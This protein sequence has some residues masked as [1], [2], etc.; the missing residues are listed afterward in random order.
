MFSK[1][2]IKAK[3]IVMLFI[4]I[5]G[6][7]GY[8]MYFIINTYNIKQEAQ[9]SKNAVEKII[10][11]GSVIHESQK[12][13][14]TT[15]GFLSGGDKNSMLSQRA[16]NDIALKKLNDQK[17]I[18]KINNIRSSVDSKSSSNLKLVA[19]YTNFIR[20]IIK[21][22]R[23][24][25]D[26]I[27]PSLSIYFN[28]AVLIGDLKESYGIFR[29]TLNSVFTKD[30]MSKD[31]FSRVVKY[32]SETSK[33]N[34]DFLE[35]SGDKF[36]SFYEQNVLSKGSYSK[37]QDFIKMALNSE[38][39]SSL[40]ADAKVWFNSVTDVIN[41]I[42]EVELWI[43]NLMENDAKSIEDS[44]NTLMGIGVF[45]AALGTLLPLILSVIIGGSLIKNINL[46]QDGLA[47]FFE[48]L[49]YEKDDAKII[50]INSNDEL[51]AMSLMIN[52]NIERTQKAI[53]QDANAINTALTSTKEI[54]NGNLSTR[55]DQ[56]AS[57]PKLCEL[58]EV[59]NKMLSMF[60]QKIGSNLTEILDIFDSYKKLD[61]RAKVPNASGTIESTLNILGDEIRKTLISSNSFAQELETK[62]NELNTCMQD[63][64]NSAKVQN[65]S[66]QNS[67]EAVK[68][69]DLSINEISN[70]SDEV[71]S[72]SE[73][74]A[75][76]VNII[77]DIAEQ[78][79]LLALNAAIEAARA[80]EHGRGFAVVADEVRSLAERTQKSLNEIETNINILSQSISTMAGMVHNQTKN[81]TEVNKTI[82]EVGELTA[83]NLH[84]AEQTN[85]L[86]EDVQHIS[87]Q[88]V[89][90]A[91]RKQY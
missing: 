86:A 82:Q 53:E 48:F 41:H 27:N 3:M 68:L 42:R 45:F 23:S 52:E 38:F 60:E 76:I 61:F 32:H 40:G 51:K 87:K 84:T 33:S 64:S 20:G 2:G 18:E 17:M 88:I 83:S 77:K 67:Q 50:N 29:A 85:S 74:I 69:I 13:R 59:L 81:I 28:N 63:I 35:F 58:I 80:G 5:V 47:S 43:L 70:I 26:K 31:D 30:N 12:E 9:F 37:T 16:E 62:A 25:Q 71:I 78:T 91:Q 79:N 54:E 44:S 34:A 6:I 56:K 89:E 36:A 90:D 21:D 1:V 57:N 66:L 11:L 75:N 73:D 4:A 15:A 39:N 72:Q 49:N 14:G 24:Y 19:N 8:S 55:I 65:V 46:L 7:F 10:L 22:I